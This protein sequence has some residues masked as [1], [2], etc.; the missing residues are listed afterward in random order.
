M[1]RNR[2]VLSLTFINVCVCVYV[3]VC[4]CARARAPMHVCVRM[5]VC[6]CVYARACVHTHTCVCVCVCVKDMCPK[7]YAVDQRLSTYM[8]CDVHPESCIFTFFSNQL[9]MYKCL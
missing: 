9:L 7:F 6:V 8:P 3:C 4:V 5:Y 2:V 1:P